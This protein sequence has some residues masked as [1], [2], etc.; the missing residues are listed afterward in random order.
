[1][2]NRF[3]EQRFGYLGRNH[4][5]GR[6]LLLGDARAALDALL[7]PAPERHDAQAEARRLYAAGDHERALLEFFKESRTERRVLA[8]LKRTGSPEKAVR[9]IERFERGFFLTALQSDIF[10]RVLDDRL[11]QGTIGELA[12]GDVAFKHDNRAVFA[13]TEETL[14]DPDTRARLERFAISPSG[15]MWG[16]SMVRAGGRAAQVEA[17]ALSALGLTPEHLER[18]GLEGERRPFRVPITFPDVEGG[19]D[20]RGH[21]VRCAF[22]LP[23]GCFATAVLREL[24]K[25]DLTDAAPRVD[26]E[27]EDDD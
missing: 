10:N 22:D 11:R 14:A 24:M 26:D 15:P 7:A 21:F 20:D 23:R 9:A 12:A 5:I 19:I 4:L 18:S 16:P 6:A 13:V 1:M 8:A 3:G 27:D 17:E 2:P 25:P